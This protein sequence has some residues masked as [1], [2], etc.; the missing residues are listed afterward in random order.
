MNALARLNTLSEDE[1]RTRLTH[2]CGSKKWVS[3]MLRSRPF[4]SVEA[5]HSAAASADASLAREDWLEAFTHHPKIGDLQGLRDRWASQEQAG[6]ARAPEALLQELKDKNDAYLAKFGYIFIV[7][8]TG[9]SA[10]EMLK[11]LSDRLHSPPERELA[12]AALEQSKI[13]RIRLEKLLAEV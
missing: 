6:A 4:E 1:L 5:L 7:C 11:I 8:A 13:T 10:A 9:K 3:L 2:C 12:V